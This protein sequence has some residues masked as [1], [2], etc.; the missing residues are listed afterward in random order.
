M[1]GRPLTIT[2]EAELATSLLQVWFQGHEAGNA[3]ADVLFGNYNPSGKLTMSFPRN[4]G[5]IPVYYNHKNTGRPQPEGEGQKFRSNYLDISNDPLFPFGYGLSYTSFSYGDILLS[6]K[7][8]RSNENLEIK[9]TVT[10]SGNYDGEETVQ[11]Y[12][13]DV[14]ASIAQPVKQLKGFQKI[15]LKKGEKKELNF[16]LT[17]QDLKFFN[18]DLKQVF[19]PGDFNVFVGTNSRDVKKA[20]FTLLK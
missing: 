19:E 11:L 17:T 4:V 13:Q 20:S 1:S 9:I 7:Q 6:K 12:V 3:I 18:Q 8:I 5:Q 14:Y 15:F 10:N 2:K 16:K